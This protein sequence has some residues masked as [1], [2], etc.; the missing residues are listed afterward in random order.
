[1]ALKDKYVDNIV[2]DLTTSSR[3]RAFEK[4]T[5]GKPTAQVSHDTGNPG[6]T[7][8]GNANWFKSESKPSS[9]AHS[10]IDDKEIRLILPLDEKA[11][12]IQRQVR[13]DERIW[14]GAANDIALG[15][16]L[17]YG[18]SINFAAAYDRWVW[19]HVYCAKQFGI[20]LSRIE[21]HFKL[22]PQR[23]TDPVNALSQ[24]GKTWN[25]FLADVK[26]YF[27][28]WEGDATPSQAGPSGRKEHTIQSGDTLWSIAT[29][30]QMSVDELQKLNPGVVAINLQPGQKL[31]LNEA[32]S[33]GSAPA[34]IPQVPNRP[35]LPTGVYS[36][37]QHGDR[38]LNAVRQIQTFSNAINF[39]VGTVD[40]RYG[41]RTEDAIR[42]FQSMYA[43]LTVDGVYGPN[44]RQFMIR[45][46]NTLN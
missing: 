4:M 46:F 33:S 31:L 13:I 32:R 18:G 23:R 27:D 40:G 44:T 16:E 34:T 25:Q 36:R 19:F 29:A 42:R 17:C 21:G 39:N 26:R 2:Y 10:F 11:W 14:G 6:S 7:A 22:D 43:A 9:S 5:G 38:S 1:M 45:H 24:N 41:P 3:S 35:P 37:R 12:H 20:P 30:N 8:R 28:A 15:H